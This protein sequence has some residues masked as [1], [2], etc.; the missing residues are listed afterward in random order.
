MKKIALVTDSSVGITLKDLKNYKDLFIAPLSIIHNG[1]E[2]VDQI[3]LSE[4][5]VN[6]ILRD[7]NII[8]TSQPSVGLCIELFEKIKA[9][10]Y[11][12]IIVVT[13]SSNLSGTFNSFSTAANEVGPDFITVLDSYSIAGPV[14][15][16]LKL[17]NRLNE[18]GKTIDEIVERLEAFFG[19]TVSY[20]IPETLDQLKASG[21]ISNAAAA[22][23]SML[24]MK[25]LLRL[26]NKGPTIEKFATARTDKKI[27]EALF[28]DIEAHGFNNDQYLF[29]ALHSDGLEILNN[30]IEEMK[31]RF[32]NPEFITRLLPAAVSGHAG[33]GTVAFQVVRKASNF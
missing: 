31:V 30:I 21:R 10:G 26:E 17:I 20:V 32:N 3:D 11:E 19:D 12:H 33:I 25:I 8:Q 13:L 16:S 2:Y 29:Y 6:E 27:L 5:D 18:E 15:E 9:L 4:E 7:N 22:L 24:K 1:K 28:K 23:A 14:Q